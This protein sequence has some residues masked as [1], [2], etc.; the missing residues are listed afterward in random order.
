VLA[1]KLAGKLHV[2]TGRDD[3]F[4]LEGAVKLLKESLARLGSDAVVEIHPGRDHKLRDK[5]IL[6]RIARE[7][8]DRYL[9]SSKR[10]ARTSG[11]RPPSLT[12]PAR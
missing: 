9:K 5:A 1:P 10:A 4:Y 11:G 3:T 2:W 7:M 12:L 8:A 6:D